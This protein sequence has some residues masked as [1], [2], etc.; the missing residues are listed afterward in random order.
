MT[1]VPASTVPTPRRRAPRSRSGRKT[2]A[3]SAQRSSG[4]IMFDHRGHGPAVDPGQLALP[5]PESSDSPDAVGPTEQP[6][7]WLD[8]RT[9]RIGKAGVRAAREALASSAHDRSVAGD[10]P[11]AR[12][13]RG[14]HQ[15]S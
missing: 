15:V 4:W 12:D 6:D 14:A 8:D 7:H 11:V 13:M 1:G 2:L 3:R 9:R 5:V 10:E